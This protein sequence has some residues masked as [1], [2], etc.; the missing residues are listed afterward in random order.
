LALAAFLLVLPTASSGQPVSGD[1]SP[2]GG[3]SWSNGVVLCVFEPAMPEVV[4]SASALANSGMTVGIASIEEVTPSGAVT[5]TTPSSVVNW[6]TTNRSSPTWYDLSYNATLRVAP[7][8]SAATSLGAV[9][10]RLDFQLPVR[11]VE[12]VT[13]NISAVTMALSVSGWPWQAGGDHLVIALGFVPAFAGTEHFA[14]VTPSGTTI[15]SVSNQS[16]RTLEYFAGG[17]EGNTTGPTGPAI[18]VT[19][20]P[21]W[22]VTPAAAAVDLSI[23]TSAGSF[24]AL[25]YTAHVGVLLPATI[26][27]IPLYEFALAGGAAALLVVVVGIGLQRVRRRPSDLVFVEEEET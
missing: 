11:Y 15:S 14:P 7:S 9:D 21:A 16:G 8:A 4:V 3:T 13:E 22:A 17:T 2:V 27:G 23:G 1:W 6:T 5:A 19:V 26:A 12:G 25:N 10:V 18:P 24:T 20:Q